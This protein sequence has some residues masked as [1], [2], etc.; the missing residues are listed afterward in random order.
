MISFDKKIKSYLE[1]LQKSP[2]CSREDLYRYADYL[3]LKCLA[4]KDSI[5]STS[6]FVDDIRPRAEDLGEGDFEEIEDEKKN[7]IS[8]A[9]K[10]D[11]WETLAK[12]VFNII[13]LR[14]QTFKDF[15]PYEMTANSL[16]INL[17][18]E[19]DL[20]NQVYFFLLFSSNLQFTGD[21]TN[22]FTS[23]FEFIS[24]EV[25]KSFLPKNAIVKLFA[26]S[27]TEIKKDWVVNESKFWDKLKYLE[28]FLK[29]KIIIEESEINRYNK[30]DGG[31][32]L[33]GKIPIDD[34]SHF[35]VIFGQCACSPD[36]WIKKQSEIKFDIWRQKINLHTIPQYYIF[37]P[38]NYRDSQGN[39]FRQSNI[40]D[41]IL[42]DRQRILNNFKKVNKFQKYA[43]F[44]IVKNIIETKENTF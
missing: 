42:I 13:S 28:D 40:H 17:K 11:K 37:I 35:P 34:Q 14:T 9:E 26:S 24:R 39:W 31:L 19:I 18:P 10:N 22:T 15:Y 21:F 5:Y 7:N 20:K 12:E 16:A 3:E 33:V 36:D 29:S 23:S 32:D 25:L 30:G 1:K 38:Q 6:D 4:N 41:T 27:N 44:E 43:S 8:K 2:N